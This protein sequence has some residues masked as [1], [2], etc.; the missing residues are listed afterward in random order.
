MLYRVRLDLPFENEGQ[1]RGLYN[2]ARNTAP[3]AVLINEGL[4]NEEVGFI[5]IEECHHDESPPLPCV[6][7]EYIEKE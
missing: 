1:A 7:I 6:L 3:D 4:E 5:D 2:H